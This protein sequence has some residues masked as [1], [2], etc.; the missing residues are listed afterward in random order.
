MTSAGGT[1]KSLRLGAA[2]A[3]AIAAI[4]SVGATSALAD[5]NPVDLQVIDR[6]TGQ[7]LR[8][9]RHRGR[10][11]V[12]GEPGGRYALRVTNQTD[13]RVLLVLS[14]DGV[15]VVTGETASYDQRGYVLSARQS[16]DVN[17]WR[18]SNAEVAAFSFAPLPQSYAARTGRPG[19]VGVIGLAVFKEKV[20]APVADLSPAPPALRRVEEPT[21]AESA[22]PSSPASGAA[23]RTKDVVV[24]AR[25]RQEKLGTAHGEREWSQARVVRFERATRYP[26]AVRQIE[27]DT[28]ANLVAAGVIPPSP[29]AERRPRPFPARSGRLGYVPDPPPEF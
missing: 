18:K 9:W 10:L 22:A 20:T 27:Y 3:A 5:Q 7:P 15:N 24:T 28:H 6:D 14:V 17:G 19:D 2:L 4:A 16:Y 12:A 29:Y 8:V 23:G 13:G 25:R 21:S 26:Q 1:R 11:F